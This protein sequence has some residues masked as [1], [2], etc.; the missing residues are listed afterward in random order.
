MIARHWA[1]RIKPE[2]AENYVQYLQEEILPHLS[3]IEGFRGA[4]IRK[5]KLQDS[6]EFLFIS[7]WASEEAIKQ[8]A[9]EDISTA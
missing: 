9:G 3:E 4:S 2:E 8:F 5:R 7:E 6:I 1:G